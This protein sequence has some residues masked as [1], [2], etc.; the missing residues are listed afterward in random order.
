MMSRSALLAVLFVL[1]PAQIHAEPIYFEGAFVPSDTASYERLEF[2]LGEGTT[3]IHVMYDY[4]VEGEQ[5]SLLRNVVDLGVYGPDGF[6]GWSGSERDAVTIAVDE[7]S[8]TPGY[9]AGPLPAGTWFVE[10]G[11]GLVADDTV[12]SWTVTISVMASSGETFTPPIPADPVLGGPG[13]YSGDLHCHSIH[14]DGSPTVA[15]IFAFAHGRGLDFLALT[16]HNNFTGHFEMPALQE[17]Y[18]DLLLMRGMEVTTYRGHANVFGPTGYV[19]YHASEPGYSLD[20]VIDQVHDGGGLFSVNHPDQIGYTNAGG[21][22]TTLG[23]AVEDTDWSRV[24]GF[25][26]LNSASTWQGLS[27]PFNVEALA[28]WDELLGAGYRPTA[29]G[30]SDDH[31]GGTGSEDDLFW[32]A[33]GTPTTVVFALE[34]SHAAILDGIRAG[35]VFVKA[36]GPDGPDLHLEA[37]CGQTA[38]MMGDEGAGPSFTAVA[39]AT[40]ADDLTL[41]VV[42]DAEVIDEVPVQGDEFEHSFE[43]LPEDRTVVRLEL[44]DGDLIVA[45]TNPVYLTYSDTPCPAAGDDDDDDDSAAAIP[46]DDG[47][48]CAAGPRSARSA[49]AAVGILLLAVLRRRI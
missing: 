44:R 42:R 48:E 17:Q 33:I 10:L 8:T 18:D 24:D 39:R 6:R 28:H 14:S 20:D 16:D 35:H 46:Q 25:E 5:G 12:T 37:T 47:C 9:V 36:N 41:R 49:L 32:G 38:L 11:A 31:K 4:E 7:A 23:W 19:D 34:L 29:V 26:V 1:L 13:W 45:L 30:G 40:G 3:S 43:V 21:T 2:D 27:N 15:E 22:F